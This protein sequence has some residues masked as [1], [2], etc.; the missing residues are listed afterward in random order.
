MSSTIFNA[1]P[2][3]M[4]INILVNEHHK[5]TEKL[6]DNQL[7]KIA[8]AYFKDTNKKIIAM[9]LAFKDV[10]RIW[11]NEN[12]TSSKTI[13]LRLVN[14]LHDKAYALGCNVSAPEHSTQEERWDWE[15]DHY[16]ELMTRILETQANKNSE[17]YGILASELLQK[18]FSY[19]DGYDTLS[20][21]QVNSNWKTNALELTKTEFSIRFRYAFQFA[22][23]FFKA[24]NHENKFSES[25]KLL[26]SD[27]FSNEQSLLEMKNKLYHLRKLLISH[28][29]AV[30]NMRLRNPSVPLPDVIP[31]YTDDQI[32]DVV[33]NILETHPKKSTYVNVFESLL[34][35]IRPNYYRNR[36]ADYVSAYLRL[37]IDEIQKNDKIPI[38]RKR[39]ALVNIALG[40]RGHICMAGIYPKMQEVYKNLK[41]PEY[42]DKV[43]TFLLYHVE[44]FKNDLLSTQ[45]GQH[46]Q[47]V[48]IVSAAKDQWGDKFGLDAEA[49]R[50]D[51]NVSI[52][53]TYLTDSAKRQFKAWCEK[54]LL[55]QVFISIRDD[56][57]EQG[58]IINYA[59]YRSRI[60]KILIESG[61][62]TN[63]VAE[64]LKRLIP[65]LAQ[66][67]EILKVKYMANGISENEAIKKAEDKV[68]LLFG[69]QT[70]IRKNVIL[71]SLRKVFK[72]QGLKPDEIEQK[73]VAVLPDKN[74]LLEEKLTM[75]LTQIFSMSGYQPWSE[76][77]NREIKK[78]L[79]DRT[80]LQQYGL[81]IKKYEDEVKA[82]FE[83]GLVAQGVN[84][85]DIED[86]IVNCNNNA[87]TISKEA[88]AMLLADIGVIYP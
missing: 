29:A 46:S 1:I 23:A 35:E 61:L 28:G 65:T 63:Q 54:G 69:D 8:L 62:N 82:Q 33:R 37:I 10:Y 36:S 14:Q 79:S 83:Q 3:S 67:K 87:V 25:I 2:R 76:D 19:L 73:I 50:K 85:E 39:E 27:W 45:F 38:H 22:A 15:W 16:E 86:E 64:E 84:L 40:C 75:T 56:K 30:A 26:E 24:N 55:E 34:K 60:G 32:L 81:N 21:M 20:V 4:F 31:E 53:Y 57:D 41:C 80:K 51:E 58:C 59:E 49:G 11:E 52:G 77:M 43:K 44:Q 12:N 88:V 5:K 42:V 71:K 17:T 7:Y 18:I 72:E 66:Y 47:S 48:H 13:F 70:M 6:N 9:N 78:L 74:K 68:K